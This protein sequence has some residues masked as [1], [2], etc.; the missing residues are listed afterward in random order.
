MKKKLALLILHPDD[1][2]SQH[3][4]FYCLASVVL[5]L[6][7]FFGGFTSATLS[8]RTLRLAV[9]IGWMAASVIAIKLFWTP[10]SAQQTRAL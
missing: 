6:L 10:D 4:A 7:L 3:R 2:S 5:I 9:L 1:E 8:A